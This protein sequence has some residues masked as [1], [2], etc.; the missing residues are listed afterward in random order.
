MMNDEE[1]S[2]ILKKLE[3]P[4]CPLI[5]PFSLE[6]LGKWK[7]GWHKTHMPK[8][9]GNGYKIFLKVLIK[10]NKVIEAYRREDGKMKQVK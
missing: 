10:D 2:K 3:N 1:I 7:D 5:N 6:I 9:N 4:N 8:K